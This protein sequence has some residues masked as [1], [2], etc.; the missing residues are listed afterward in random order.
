MGQ[1]CKI[2]TNRDRAVFL[3]PFDLSRK[4]QAISK[5]DNQNRMKNYRVMLIS[6][7]ILDRMLAILAT[8]F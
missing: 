5:N 3:S 4:K 1:K 2:L 7:P 6:W 8:F